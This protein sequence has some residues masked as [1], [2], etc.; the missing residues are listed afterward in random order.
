MGSDS[1]R[2]DWLNGSDEVQCTW[3]RNYIAKNWSHLPIIQRQSTFMISNQDYA[4]NAISEMERQPDSKQ[5]MNAIRSAW[6]SHKNRQKNKGDNSH[7]T[8]RLSTETQRRLEQLT[9]AIKSDSWCKTIGYLINK[10]YEKVKLELQTTEASKQEKKAHKQETNLKNE[11]HNKR[12]DSAYVHFI[13]HNKIKNQLQMAKEKIVQLEASL[14]NVSE[15]LVFKKD[16]IETHIEKTSLFVDKLDKLNL[17]QITPNSES[18]VNAGAPLEHRSND[19]ELMK[20]D[21][22]GL[23]KN[24]PATAVNSQITNRPGKARKVFR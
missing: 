13:E 9:K 21:S 2:A 4:S 14:G 22:A 12:L 5:R 20:P 3:A 10:Q 7:L 19:N 24:P 8:I 18:N 17:Q 16:C 15:E 11:E 23:Q 6:S 1:K